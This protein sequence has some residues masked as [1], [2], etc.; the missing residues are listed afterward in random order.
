MLDT[1]D[2]AVNAGVTFGSVFF[3]FILALWWDRKQK[4]NEMGQRKLITLESI[5]GEIKEARDK[6]GQPNIGVEVIVSTRKYEST[7]PQTLTPA[8][9]SAV[10]SG[11]Y[12]LLSA[13]LQIKLSNVYYLI[14]YCNR[15]R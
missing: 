13:D 1:L 9:E 11:N 5:I 10:N 15:G 6:F 7:V 12:S 2:V 3:A 14:N 8:Y 4:R